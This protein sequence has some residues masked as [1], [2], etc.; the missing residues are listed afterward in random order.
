MIVNIETSDDAEEIVELL[1]QVHEEHRQRRPQW[2]KPF[3]PTAALEGQRNLL[4]RAGTKMFVARVE[5]VC[6]GYALVSERL[7]EENA[8]RYA[9]RSL[10]VDQMAVSN[11]H[12]RQGFGTLLMDRIRAEAARRGTQSVELNV[13]SDNDDA[14][15]FYEAQGFVRFQNRMEWSP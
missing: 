6:V 9:S 5:G 11:T 15:R 7:R 12:R 13:Y 4:S 8:F 10:V 14:R 1:R 3:D 2:F